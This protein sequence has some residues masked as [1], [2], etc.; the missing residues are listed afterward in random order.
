MIAADNPYR[1]MSQ[2]MRERIAWA[3]E[4]LDEFPRRS[5]RNLYYAQSGTMGYTYDDMKRAMSVGRLKHILGYDE[6]TDHT[7]TP[8]GPTLYRG[9]AD[10][11][12]VVVNAYR[13]DI[14]ST[15]TQYVEV[16]CESNATVPM[17]EDG[18]W[19]LG[20]QLQPCGGDLTLYPVYMAA[21]RFQR[22]I[23]AGR[24]AVVIYVGDWNPKGEQI[25]RSIKRN[26]LERH[27]VEVEFVRVAITAEQIDEHQLPA[28][29]PGK[30]K[31]G[32]HLAIPWI[33]KHGALYVE[34]E[35]MAPQTLI[36]IV[37]DAVEARLDMKAWARKQTLQT[38]NRRKL[39]RQL[40]PGS[41]S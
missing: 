37:S 18:T 24:P 41:A 8:V 13:Q 22:H 27:G 4:A 28:K 38:R 35:A 34:V 9:L 21:Q 20:V 30:I 12:T 5:L 39:E 36:E 3:R 25:P 40:Q 17:L 10:F 31:D 6:I 23:D 15:Q 1:G 19:E 7:R 14:W 2:S 29:K 33:K 11:A 32:D 16:W 26:L